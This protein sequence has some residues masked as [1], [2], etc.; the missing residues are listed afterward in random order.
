MNSG[1]TICEAIDSILIQNHPSIEVTVVDGGSSDQTINLLKQYG[2]QI[3][4]TSEPDCG[5]T[6]ALIKGFRR[7]NGEILTWLNADDRLTPHS[8]QTVDQEF[9][10][11]PSIDFVYG[12][13]E[14]IDRNGRVLSKRLE[15]SFS[16][17]VLLYGHNLFADPTCFWRETVF[18]SVGPLDGTID[19]SMDYE[20]WVR[21]CDQKVQFGQIKECLAQYR[22]DNK[23][24]SID[25]FNAMRREH[26]EIMASRRAWLRHLPKSIRLALLACL[27]KVSRTWKI[28]KTLLERR[29][30]PKQRFSTML[31][32]N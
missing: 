7:I 8:L 25:Q 5:Q 16:S 6:D 30:L 2:D 15:P 18:Q 4:W 20:F 19:L 3:S 17:F 23:N 26:F 24:R 1:R 13:I 14:F 32:K 9:Q 11:N 27:L 22:V 21:C 29:A 31:H 28:L 12:D 10:Q